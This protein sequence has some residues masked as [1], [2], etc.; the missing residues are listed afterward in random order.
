MFNIQTAALSMS[1]ATYLMSFILY[2]MNFFQAKKQFHQAAKIFISIAF[3][4]TTVSVVTRTIEVGH[5]PFSSMFEFGLSFLWGA[6]LAFLVIEFKFNLPGLGM[7]FTP[8]ACFASMWLLTM[9]Q[10]AAP[11]MPALRSN[12]LYIHVFTAIIAYGCFAVSFVTALMYLLKEQGLFDSFLPSLE[13]LDNLTYK[14]ISF[15]MPFMTLLII[16]GAIWAEDAWGNYWSWDPKETWSL[17]TWLIYAGYLHTRLIVGWKG[18]RS[19]FF[20]ILGFLA[21]LFTFVGVSY[22]LPGMH[23]YA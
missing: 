1:F 13:T 17:I 12:W 16:T 8:L 22:L 9:N 21:V 14:I 20:A 4:F 7:F 15:A 2:V 6:L 3:I 11:L 18:R 5:L 23:S 19:I 10:E